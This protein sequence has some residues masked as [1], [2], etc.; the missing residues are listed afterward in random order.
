MS[1]PVPPSR[2]AQLRALAH[3]GRLSVL[4]AVVSGPAEGTP[5]GRIQEQVGLPAST[6]SHHLADLA[7]AELV[8]A[9]R[10]GTTI[11]YRVRFDQLRGLTEF[12]WEDCCG[13]GCS[14]PD[15]C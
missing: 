4:R 6:L 15:C 9:A 7:K 11:R 12:L 5:V 3:P 14:D 8:A 1:N 2:V 13:G 10:Q